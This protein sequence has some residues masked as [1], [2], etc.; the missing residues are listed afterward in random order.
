MRNGWL[1]GRLAVVG[2]VTGL[3][4]GT[5]AAAEIHVVS[6]GG[7]AEAYLAVAPVFEHETGNTLVFERG[8]SMGDTHDAVPQRLARGE[9]VDVVI[10]VGYALGKLVDQGKASDRVDLARSGI[11]VA[12]RKGAPVP[13]ISTV[14]ALRKT[15]LAAKSIGYSESASGVYIQNEM[16]DKLGIK[17]QVK[18]RASMVKGEPVAALVARGEI[19]LGF[20]QLSELMPIP[21]ITIVGSL[22]DGAQQITVFS[23]GMAT[24]SKVPDAARAL[25]HFLASPAAAKAITD[26]GMEPIGGK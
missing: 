1:L 19:E 15:M 21:G 8:A 26:S 18:A 14:D 4:A 25:I 9:P 22:P 12:V 10:M 7:F 23:A 13:D 20:Q 5:A 17:D 3:L 24:G 2:V 6:S 11:G 16:L